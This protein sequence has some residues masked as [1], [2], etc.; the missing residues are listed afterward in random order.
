MKIPLM[1]LICRLVKDQGNVL[2]EYQVQFDKHIFRCSFLS[3][4]GARFGLT[5]VQL[6]L[7]HIVSTFKIERSENTPFPIKYH[8]TGVALASTVGLPMR[9]KEIGKKKVP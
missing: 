3:V 1:L 9:F 6:G 2:V 4:L 5:I 8:T 7:A